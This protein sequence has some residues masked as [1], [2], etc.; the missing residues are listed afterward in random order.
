[1]DEI[2][3]RVRAHRPALERWLR[4]LPGYAGYKEK[5]LRREADRLMV[6]M[7]ILAERDLA[8]ADALDEVIRRI[9][10]MADRIQ[11]ASYGYAGFFDAVH[12]GER[13][14]EALYRFDADLL[15]RLEDLETFTEAFD[16]ALRAG[17]DPTPAFHHLDGTS[18]A[19]RIL[20]DRRVEALAQI[21]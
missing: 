6:L 13:E 4:A 15:Q 10:T 11:V 17:E 5:E 3:E 1:M 8:Q 20:W 21:L 12:I 18:L 7:G 2:L 16:Q 9:Q 14:L 19:L